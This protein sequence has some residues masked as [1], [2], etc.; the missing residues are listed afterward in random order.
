M[1]AV[2]SAWGPLLSFSGL[3]QVLCPLLAP[4][5]L[6]AHTHK[7]L[8]GSLGASPAPLCLCS[9]E[10]QPELAPEQ[11]TCREPCP[12]PESWTPPEHSVS[13]L[14]TCP[15]PP[16]LAGRPEQTRNWWRHP[17]SWGWD[18]VLGTGRLL[19][20]HPTSVKRFLASWTAPPQALTSSGCNGQ[21]K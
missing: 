4:A 11:L 10:A 20:G 13:M 16:P 18:C 21:I 6:A 3:T 8:W 14:G 5:A 9:P 2:P 19:H 15:T 7:P 12:R 17:R 1:G